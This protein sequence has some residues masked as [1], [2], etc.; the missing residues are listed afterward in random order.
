MCKSRSC[1]VKGGVTWSNF[2]FWDFL[3]FPAKARHLQFCVH[4]DCW[5]PNQNYAKV[6]HPGS[7]SGSRD[8]TFDFA[9]PFVSLECPKLDTPA[10]AVCVVHSMQPLPNYFGLL[11]R[12]YLQLTYFTWLII[13]KQ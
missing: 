2:K 3:L 9:D 1:G 5:G 13:K 4:I 11:L 10:R 12:L 8:Y 7:G 6:L